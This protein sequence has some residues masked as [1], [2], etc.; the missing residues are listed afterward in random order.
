MIK[1][2][3]L[4][5]LFVPLRQVSPS[6]L[7]AS[8]ALHGL[9]FIVPIPDSTDADASSKVKQEL[10]EGEIEEELFSEDEEGSLGEE[11]SLGEGDAIE[12]PGEPPLLDGL[13][14]GSVDGIDGEEIGDGDDTTPDLA[15]GDSS[16]SLDDSD[17]SIGET[18]IDDF[19]ADGDDTSLEELPTP[20]GN[21]SL[22]EPESEAEVAFTP[23]LAVNEPIVDEPIVDEPIVDEPIV[24]EP[25][26]D[27]PVVDEPVVDEPIVDEP[28][29]DEPV[30]DEPVVDEPVVDEPVVDEPV[31]DE[32]T[33][34]DTD[35][36]TELAQPETTSKTDNQPQPRID[37]FANFPNYI[38]VK[39][40]FCGV[41]SARI[42]RRTRRTSDSLDAVQAY[43]DKKLAGTDFQVEKLADESD[44]KVYQIS[45]G[46]LTQYLQLFT[47]EEGTMILLSYERVDCYRL[48]DRKQPEKPKAEEQLNNQLYT[49]LNWTKEEKGAIILALKKLP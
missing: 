41:Q 31:V 9:L 13:E 32:P 23:S 28:I 35:T 6:M 40:N 43:F 29:V 30:V 42:D 25:I 26:V 44:T 48:S 11:D 45:K 7:L 47:V 22:G 10:S 14:G 36:T 1:S 18:A 21:L 39:P 33:K 27:E 17:A 24:D 37:P 8:A 38:S 4:N 15:P 34:P 49:Q 12:V 46:N 2:F 16:D 5:S 20:S 19:G 3:L